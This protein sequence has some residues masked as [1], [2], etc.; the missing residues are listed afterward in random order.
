MVGRAKHVV[1]IHNLRENHR[2]VDTEPAS[3]E[4]GPGIP[5]ERFLRSPLTTK[6]FVRLQSL[7]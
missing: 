2:N 6:M 5:S 1:V 4:K 3:A 7:K